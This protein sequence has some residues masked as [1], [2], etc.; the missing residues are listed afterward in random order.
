MTILGSKK[1]IPSVAATRL[2]RWEILLS[3]YW[4]EIEF[5]QIHHHYNADALFRLLLDVKDSNNGSEATLFIIYQIE[6]LPVT[7]TRATRHD[8][9]FIQVFHF[10]RNSWPEHMFEQLKT[11]H[12]KLHETSVEEDYGVCVSLFKN[13]YKS[14]HSGSCTET[15]QETLE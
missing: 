5:W 6:T 10:T 14:V 13:V 15:T 8:P 12:A 11:F 2:Q 9:A 7:A 3:G 1:G 4:Y